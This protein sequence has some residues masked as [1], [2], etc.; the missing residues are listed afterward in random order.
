MATLTTRL[1]LRKPADDGSEPVN[2]ATDL[3]A[4]WD[5]LDENIGITRCLS[6]DHPADPYDGMPIKEDDT[7]LVRIWNA[8]TANWDTVTVPPEVATSATRP[9]APLAGDDLYETDTQ[10]KTVYTGSAWRYV[11]VPLV[12]PTVDAVTI[13]KFPGLEVFE[14]STGHKRLWDGTA[15]RYV[16]FE[17]TAW[18]A[19]ALQSGYSAH[20][21]N[22]GYPPAYRFV[23]PN[24][25]EMRGTI[26][27]GDG[28]ATDMTNSFGNGDVP[29]IVPTPIKPA[30]NPYHISRSALRNTTAY[31]WSISLEV[32]FTTGGLVVTLKSAGDLY[33][34]GWLALDGFVYDLT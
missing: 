25:V 23:R 30:A 27:K 31:G 6:T 22:F 1:G 28:A 7:G 11:G 33:M 18:T 3:N 8:D 16:H 13:T 17:P 21:D 29:L 10:A 24:T 20:N 5:V 26:R 9:G 19:L 12:E 14:T 15:W 2:V 32:N 34:P 4:N